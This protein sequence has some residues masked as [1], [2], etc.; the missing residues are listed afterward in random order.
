MNEVTIRNSTRDEIENDHESYSLESAMFAI[1]RLIELAENDTEDSSYL[2]G[3]INDLEG[4]IENL[5]TANSTLQEEV[6]DLEEK[7]E[8]AEALAD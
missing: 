8:E 1:K 5:E 3:E 4:S 7:L 2:H 6:D